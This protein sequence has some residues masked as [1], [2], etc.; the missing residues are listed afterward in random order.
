MNKMKEDEELNIINLVD[1][2]KKF[3]VFHQSK[4]GSSL[5]WI[6]LVPWD[7]SFSQLHSENFMSLE[8]GIYGAF[9]LRYKRFSKFISSKNLWSFKSYAPFF[10]FPYLFDKSLLKRCFT[11]D[12]HLLSNPSGYLG[13]VFMIFL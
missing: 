13:F 10:K 7:F 3:C 11:N 5:D 8:S 12:L 6:A 1:F 4:K 9:N 2:W